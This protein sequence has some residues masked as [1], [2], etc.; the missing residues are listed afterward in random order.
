MRVLVTGAA[1]YVGRAVVVALAAAGQ[2]PVALVHSHSDGLPVGVE[3]RAADLTDPGSLAGSVVGFDAVCHLAGATRAR[4][5]WEQPGRYFS[6]NTAGTI[7][8]LTAMEAAG[9]QRIVFASTGSI[10]GTPERQP[11]DESL[12]DDPPHPYAGSKLA[13]EQAVEWQARAGGLGVTVLRLFNVAGRL[14]PDSTRIVPRVLAAVDGT[15]LQVNGDGTAVRDFL[16][17][18]DAAAAFVAALER[19]V[20]VGEARRYNIGHGVGSSVMD[21]VAAAEQVTGRVVRVEH[22][23]P[24]P[25]PAT[26]VCDPSRAIAE[27][28]WKPRHSDLATIIADA[29]AATRRAGAS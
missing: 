18:D 1:G 24:A 17:V 11:M 29:W 8:L 25:E 19:A 26:L 23:P 5:S 6:V 21:V 14:D 15:D 4:E 27:L 13:A 16:H 10:Y 22:R 7:A 28:D 12:P 9:V 3:V 20:P 2:E